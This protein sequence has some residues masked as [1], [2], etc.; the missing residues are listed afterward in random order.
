MANNRRPMADGLEPT[1][2]AN[3]KQKKRSLNLLAQAAQ[4]AEAAPATPASCHLMPPPAEES[5]IP[6]T[7]LLSRRDF[8]TLVI[9]IELT[10]VSIIQG[11]ALY[12]LTDNSREALSHLQI[13]RWI[14]IGNGLLIIFVFWCRAVEHTLTLVRWPLHFG[15]NFLY[16]SC[17]M[18]QAISF[19]QL[20]DPLRWFAFDALF[21]LLVWLLFVVDLQLVNRRASEAVGQAATELY[22]LIRRDQFRNI[23]WLVP[24]L[25][26]F[27]LA[28]ALFIAEQ[29]QLALAQRG[30]LYF[31]AAQTVSLIVYLVYSLR[32]SGQLATLINKVFV[33]RAASLT[34][35]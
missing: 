22:R 3:R 13:D 26:V 16:I 34:N 24:A 35:P 30:H 5:E 31:A 8:D 6:R 1:A 25:F 17:A 14:Y 2:N 23:L 18:V 10:L 9:N 32:F 29:P 19:T 27:N 20:A 12:F 11:V 21:A 7:D 28:A 4:P 33:E 15:R